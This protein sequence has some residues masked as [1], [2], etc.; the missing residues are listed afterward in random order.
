MIPA[1]FVFLDALPL[2]A[3]GKVDRRRL[4]DLEQPGTASELEHAF[5][6][7]RNTI[8]K[9]LAQLWEEILSIPR[10]GVDDN[11]FTLGGNSLRAM[12]LATRL[13]KLYP[14]EFEELP[15]RRLFDNP[16]IAKLAAT[17]SLLNLDAELAN[18]GLDSL[19]SLVS[20]PE[21]RY[22]PFPLTEVQQAYW[23][24]R[25]PA[26]ELG[27]IAAHGYLEI[28][29]VNVDMDRFSRAWQQLIKRHEMLRAIVRPDGQ[30]QIL[31]EVPPY[32]IALLNL[33]G[34]DEMRVSAEL[35]A[36][37][38]AMSHQVRPADQ[39]PLFEIRASQCDAER[40]RVHISFDILIGDASSF[41]IF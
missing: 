4:P 41:R 38:E 14:V 13:N 6:A 7:P 34:L 12:Q 11:F 19:P 32:E 10:V 26:F 28:D 25:S 30:Q 5:V 35:E 31:E 18:P 15:L 21:Q 16:T 1:A 37:R 40:T 24:G 9:L 3:T 22:Q 36:V 29:S 17:M 8:E 33:R 27:N 39:W 20:A 23:F 2:T